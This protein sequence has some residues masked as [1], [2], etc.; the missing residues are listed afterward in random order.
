MNA[1]LTPVEE[2]RHIVPIDDLREH[3]CDPSC[4]CNPTQD[5]EE[6]R[7]WVHHS[8]DLR[9]EFEQGRKPS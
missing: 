6:P 4:W 2:L 5:E 9:E 8:M 1:P 3:I 7:L